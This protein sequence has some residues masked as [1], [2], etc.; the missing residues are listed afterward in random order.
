MCLSQIQASGQRIEYFEKLQL[1]FK[2]AIPLKIPLHNNTRWG[3]AH[4]MLERSYKLRQVRTG[5]RTISIDTYSHH[6]LIPA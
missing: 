1:Q 2:I 3:T 4:K 6:I 5:E